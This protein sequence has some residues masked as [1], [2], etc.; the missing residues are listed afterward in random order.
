MPTGTTKPKKES[1]KRNASSGKSRLKPARE[2]VFTKAVQIGIVVRDLDATL[3]RYV[4]DYGIGPWEIHEFNP[5]SAKDLC[6]DGR[7][8]KRS[9]R[10]AFTMVGDVMWELIEPLDSKSIYARFLAEKGEG[11]H[12]IAV[13]TPDFEG[14]VAA[15]AKRR[16]KLALSGTF[17]GFKVAYLPTD[18]D[19]GVILEIFKKPAV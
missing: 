17:S 13:A 1:R 4:D 19:I 2:P 14:A 10:L 12:H 18:R 15:Q 8:A 6:E 16:R 11:V 3:R 5:E 9:W 7:P